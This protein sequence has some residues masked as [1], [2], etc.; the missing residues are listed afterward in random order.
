MTD[1]IPAPAPPSSPA[2]RAGLAG[3]ETLAALEWEALLALIADEA[4]TDL[5]AQRILALEPTAD[6]EELER[7]RRAGAEVAALA[8]AAAFVP[9]LGEPFADLLERLESGRPPLDGSE[10]LLL[11]RLLSVA[12][13]ALQR[14]RAADPAPVELLRLCAELTDPAPLLA[15]V[16]RV[17]D[18]KGQV[19]DDASPR[20]G[21]LRREVQGARER[22]YGRLEQLRSQHLDLFGEETV[23]LRGGRLLLVLSAGARGR[24]PGLVHGRSA[25]GRSFYFEPLDAV[26]DNNQL[27]T[28]MEE[29]EAER[30]RLLAE[31]LAAFTSALP[32]VRGLAALVAELD[33]HETAGRWARETG[34]RWPELCADGRLRLVAARHPLLEPRLAARRER[35]LG[36]SGHTGEAVPLDLE[37]DAA[38]RVLVITGPN[39]G[40]KTVAAKTLGLAVLA[41]QSGLPVACAAGSELPIFDSLVATVGD[42]QDLLADRSTFSGRL[43]RLS[44]AWREAG[45]RALALLDELGSGTDPEEGA[46][47]GVA[48]LEHLLAAGGLAIITTHLGKVAAAAIERDGA[49]CAAMEFDPDSGRP[50]FRLRPGAPGGSEALALG[51]RLGLPAAWLER[52]EALLGTEHRELRRVLAELEATR[53]GLARATLEAEAR[54]A[55]AA[56]LTARL[57]RERAAL[58]AERRVVG[59]RLE[60]ELRTFREQVGRQLRGVEERLRRE[61]EEG[62]RRGVAAAATA[63]LFAAA[64]ELASD[65]ARETPAGELAVGGRV[66]HRSLGWTGRLEKLDGE[67]AE[68]AVSGKR[69]RA[70]RGELIAVGD[71]APQSAR[72]TVAADDGAAPAPAE[73]ML[74]GSTVEDALLA[75]DDFL[76]R[77]LRAE[78]TEVRLVHGHGTGRLRDALRQHL[79]RHAAAQSWRPGAPNEGGNGATVVTLR[80]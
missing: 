49:A 15:H 50:L 6:R 31:L 71:E 8:A 75:V 61:F 77:A 63:Q 40:G 19:R 64:P 3:P 45:P 23:P 32:Q 70:R 53:A 67:R 73:L 30:R 62:R 7:R 54:E 57:E 9:S 33:Q 52:A 58:E 21:E 24:L 47:L 51:R 12:G 14:I 20:L 41:A 37:L 27:Q 42:E 10:I 16:R 76:D 68:V 29:Q 28:A 2:P 74:I 22:L 56:T 34:G 72:R 65:G 46:A 43:V 69:V 4:R 79:R 13:E 38:Q 25:S 11:A 26:E 44:E 35:V 55:E 1:P 39:A 5:G 17:L 36:A 80:V 48:L 66:R 60:G 78:R 59:R 18:R